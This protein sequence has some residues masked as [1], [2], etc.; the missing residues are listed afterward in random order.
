VTRPQTGK[1][2]ASGLI[3]NLLSNYQVVPMDSLFNTRGKLN[4]SPGDEPDHY[5]N[6]PSGVHADEEALVFDRQSHYSRTSLQSLTTTLMDSIESSWAARVGT[7]QTTSDPWPHEWARNIRDLCQRRDIAFFFKQSA[8]FKTEMGTT[9]D[10][11]QYREYPVPRQV[12]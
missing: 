8:A 6:L 9:L 3:V 10:G 7:A 11:R 2:T 5:W 4:A 1:S 12:I